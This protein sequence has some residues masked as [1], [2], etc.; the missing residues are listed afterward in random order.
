MVFMEMTTIK[1]VDRGL[2]L[3]EEIKKQTISDQHLPLDNQKQRE[4]ALD[5][6]KK[7]IPKTGV[8]IENMLFVWNLNN[9]LF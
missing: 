3:R 2:D 9:C 5:V 1:G 7:V 8:Q 6:H 4:N